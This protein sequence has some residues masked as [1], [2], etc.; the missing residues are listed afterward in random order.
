MAN[1]L[2]VKEVI[3]YLAQFLVD[4]SEAN[5]NTEIVVDNGKNLS[6]IKSIEL[7]KEGVDTDDETYIRII[8]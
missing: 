4:D 1:T 5:I 8:T 7:V 3:A 6:N 2:K